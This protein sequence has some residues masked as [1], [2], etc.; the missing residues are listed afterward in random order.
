[1]REPGDFTR[2]VRGGVRA[3]RR[4]LVVYRGSGPGP[5][6]RVGFIVS[7]TL[8]NAVLR[9]RVRRRL[10][11]AVATVLPDLHRGEQWVVRAL[12]A[13]G[14]TS[15]AELTSDVAGAMNLARRRAGAP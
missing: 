3:G 15:V 7:K 4:S 9:N 10:R 13:A 2:T 14:Q 8:G 12:P 1:M 6:P 5:Q 11:A